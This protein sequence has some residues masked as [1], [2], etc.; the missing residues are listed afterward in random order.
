MTTN[1][2]ELYERGNLKDTEIKTEKKIVS[3]EVKVEN[4]KEIEPEQKDNLES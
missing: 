4:S 3:Q 2:N 1:L